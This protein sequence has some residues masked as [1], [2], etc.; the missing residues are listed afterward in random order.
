MG[1]SGYGYSLQTVSRSSTSVSKK[2]KLTFRRIKCNWGS[3]EAWKTMGFRT[4]SSLLHSIE[5]LVFGERVK[6]TTRTNK[7]M[8]RRVASRTLRIHW[9]SNTAFRIPGKS[10]K[11]GYL[12]YSVL[13]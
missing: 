5:G 12:A 7:R 13:G 11:S 2:A 9:G 8:P 10:E 1:D 3:S 6:E 4:L